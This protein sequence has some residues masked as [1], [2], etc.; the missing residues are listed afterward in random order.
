MTLGNKIKEIRNRFGYSQDDLASLI[1]VS[2]QAV[3]KWEC[4]NGIPD[5]SNLQEI[6]KVFGVTVD[7]LLND[8]DLP[9]LTMRIELDKN[10]YKSKLSSYSEVLKEYFTDYE[11]FN[12]TREKKMNAA[13]FIVDLVVGGSAPEMI[14]P[15]HT[16]D[17]FSDLS[18][19]Y[20]VIR[21]NKKYLV[22]IKKWILEV[23]E[24]EE[25]INEKK[26]IYNGNIFRNSGKLKLKK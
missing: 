21:E 16:A 15:I 11:I 6:S 18:P 2:R 1:N 17:V 5:I 19:Y 7:S 9:L 20:L 24:L 23:V 13:E 12:L 14:Y 22:N 25:G 4:D 10:N 26:F 8:K 3:T